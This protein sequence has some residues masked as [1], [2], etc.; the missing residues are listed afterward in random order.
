MHVEV[1]QYVCI[2]N[3]QKF[4]QLKQRNIHKFLKLQISFTTSTACSGLTSGYNLA[5]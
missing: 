4:N 5:R 2:T 3:N 1:D